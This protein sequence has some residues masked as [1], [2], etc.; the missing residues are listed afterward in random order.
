[1][2]I[3]RNMTRRDFIASFS[4]FSASLPWIALLSSEHVSAEQNCAQHVRLGIIGVGS[5]GQ[6]LMLHLQQIPDCE[7][8]AI[9]DNYPPNLYEGKR[10]TAGK[11]WAAEDYRKLLELSN[12]DGVV[13]ATPLHLHASMTID[14]LQAGKHVFC[15]KCMALNPDDCYKMV[16]AHQETKK[17][18]Q[19]GFQRLFDIRYLK[20]IEQVKNGDIG[21]ITMIRAYWHRNHDWRRAVPRPELERK[22]NWRLYEQ[23]SGGLMAELAAHQIQVANWLLDGYPE[24][25]C[26]VGSINFWND[27][28]EV[29]DNV[30][31]IFSYPNGVQCIYDSLTSNKFYGLEEQIMGQKGTIELERGKIY[32]ENPPPAPGILQLI[33]NIENNIF[34]SIPIGGVSWVPDSAMEYEGEYLINQRHIPDAT[35]LEMEAFV[36][37]IRQQ[38][39]IEG[40]VEQA[41]YA[42]VAALLANK[43]MKERKIIHWPEDLKI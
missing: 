39:Q 37:S 1:M 20:A 19:I 41:Y 23:Y 33:N 17:N 38:R 26:G 27:G 22:I 32:S 15:E 31:A 21:P 42:S 13:I 40:I 24:T 25:V 43:A 14:A 36:T 6:K 30:S 9:C 29:F 11:A 7:I 18:L 5:R 12:L 16:M 3:E 35:Q 28:R 4:A 10:I 2:K 34:D 8:T